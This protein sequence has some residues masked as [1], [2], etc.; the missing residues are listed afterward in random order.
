MIKIKT[1]PFFDEILVKFTYLFSWN[2][3]WSKL[4]WHYFYIFYP[5]ASATAYG[6][7]PKFFRTKHSA[8]AKGENCAYG[9]TLWLTI[10]KPFQ[11]EKE[12]KLKKLATYRHLFCAKQ[13]YVHLNKKITHINNF[14]YSTQKK[15]RQ[16]MYKSFL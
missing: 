5:T 9:P 8:T 3:C 10:Q 11:H 4:W 12:R 6:Q 2:D 16:G 1:N 7:R 13:S 15:I 14:T